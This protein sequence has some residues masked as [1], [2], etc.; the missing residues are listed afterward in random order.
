MPVYLYYACASICNYLLQRCVECGGSAETCATRPGSVDGNGIPD[1]D[2]VIYVST[3]LA[4]GTC[5]PGSGV[6]AFAGTCQLESV[7]DR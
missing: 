7:L 6:I 4:G 2:I 5:A 3:S 1:T